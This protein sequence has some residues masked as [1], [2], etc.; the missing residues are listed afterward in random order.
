MRRV[1]DLDPAD[2]REWHELAGH[3]VQAH[4]GEPNG[5]IGNGLTLNQVRF[6]HADTHLALDLIGAGPP[7]G[8]AHQWPMGDVDP[9]SRLSSY[10]PFWPAPGHGEDDYSFRFPSPSQT[11]L[12]HTGTHQRSLAQLADC[13]AA[14]QLPPHLTCPDDAEE[15]QWAYRA[16]K[17]G[18]TEATRSDW[19]RA[20]ADRASARWLA[21]NHASA[22]GVARSSF[23]GQQT[24]QLAA[25]ASPDGR[26]GRQGRSFASNSREETVTLPGPQDHELREVPATDQAIR[27]KGGAR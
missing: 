4:G 6:A 7:D 10:A 3:L 1:T 15:A 5:L 27:G 18:V 9:A 11:G 12:P 16:G 22:V 14:G 8:H 20:C 2:V 21:G 24:G 13:W 17:L 25:P 19:I 23:P 26:P